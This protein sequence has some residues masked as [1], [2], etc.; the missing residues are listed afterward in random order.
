M[1]KSYGYRIVLQMPG[2]E[3]QLRSKKQRFYQFRNHPAPAEAEMFAYFIQHHGG[4]YSIFAPPKSDRLDTVELAVPA[5][6]ADSLFDLTQAFFRT[7]RFA[8]PDT[9]RTGSYTIESDDVPGILQISWHGQ[10]LMGRIN[11]LHD[12]TTARQNQAFLR[13]NRSFATLPFPPP[14]PRNAGP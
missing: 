10:T 9:V 13:V 5:A 3:F 14:A 8:N 1:E 11:A 7:L 2:E 6:R 12:G 4:G